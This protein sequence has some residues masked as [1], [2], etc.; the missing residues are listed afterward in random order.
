VTILDGTASVSRSADKVY[1]S[2]ED[3]DF[4]VRG[5]G[6]TGVYHGESPIP[7]SVA[8]E[9]LRPWLTTGVRGPGASSRLEVSAYPN[10]F[11]PTTTVSITV[12]EPGPVRA[13]VFDVR[14]RRV[15]TLHDGPLAAGT[16]Q[17]VWRPEQA[18]ASGVYFLRVSS[19]DDSRSLKLTVLR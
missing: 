3:A 7:T 6:V 2:R 4:M 10:P 16:H 9:Y 17:M 5:E 8:G 18:P 1:L 15:A 11:N 13:E 12:P 14:G 19:A